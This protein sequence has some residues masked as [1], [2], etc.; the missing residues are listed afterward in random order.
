MLRRWSR[1]KR[2]MTREQKAK[3]EMEWRRINEEIEL[4][5]EGIEPMLE[6]YLDYSVDT[7]GTVLTPVLF[8]S[9]DLFFVESGIPTAYLILK[10]QMIYYIAFRI[11]NV[12]FQ[13]LCDV[14]L[15]NSEELIFG[16][17]IFDYIS[18]Q[19]YRFSVREHRWALRNSIFDESINQKL[20][21][22]DM[23]CFS[24]Q[25]YYLMGMF[26]FGFIC[27]F[28]G[29]T[30]IVNVNY[31]PLGD[32]AVILLILIVIFFAELFCYVYVRLAN[33]QFRRLGW[34]G[35]WAT[36]LVEGTVDDDVAA[37]LA[38][39]EG[40]QADLEQERLELQALN[41]DRFRHRFLEK[42][43]PWILQHLVDLLTPRTVEEPGPDGRPTIE[44]LRD[45]YA[46]LLSLGEGLRRPGDREDISSDEDDDA[47]EDARRNWSR[48]P[49]TGGALA[50]ARMWLAKARKRRHFGKLIATTME[51]NRKT[52]CEICGRNPIQHGIRLQTMIATNGQ[53]DNHGL[54]KLITGFEIEHGYVILPLFYF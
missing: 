30:I 33:M 21:K 47:V 41:S 18:Y 53:P 11:I 17:R 43:R 10:N 42:N 4:R 13:L 14:F 7:V 46:S 40:K 32:P 35:L 44:Y 23:L 5:N 28:L 52:T 6:S 31:N 36:K 22:T 54:D 51:S 50:I 27:I 45:V 12:P 37:K 8:W 49:L 26:G 25:Y 38:I 2:R 20:Q 29:I 34:R 19:K 39:G 16:W 9:L 3:E 1:G 15:L 48:Q 24:S